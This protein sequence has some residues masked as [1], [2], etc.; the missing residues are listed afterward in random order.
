MPKPKGILLGIVAL[1]ALGIGWWLGSPL[2][3][4]RTVDEAFPMA[5]NA[6]VPDTMSRAD[7]ERVMAVEAAVDRPASEAMPS[8]ASPTVL[9]QG[10]FRDADRFHRGKGTATIYRFESGEH[11]LRFENFEVTNGP[12]LRVLLSPHPDPRTRDDVNG[13]NYVEVG[14]LKG[15]MGNQNYSI[16]PD[17][18]VAS[19]RSVIIYC[20]PFHVVFSVALL[21]EETS[22]E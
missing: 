14:K 16:P 4:N 19:H 10:R 21:V 1:A 20:R 22:A 9:K 11:V 12:D 15:N 17:V 5:A 2:F 8:G 3:L 7:V 18:D 13:A 6:V